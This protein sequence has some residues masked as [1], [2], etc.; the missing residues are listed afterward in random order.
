MNHT[1]LLDYQP[2]PA[3]TGFIARAMLT[4]TGT[5]PQN[6]ARVPLNLSLVLDRSG[7]MS[8]EKL[9]AATQAAAQ[10]VRR[11]AP[12]DRVNVVAFDDEIRTV[13]DATAP[14]PG[15][16]LA[17]RIL[18][19]PA[20][21]S[22]NLSGGW[23]RG[24][25]LAKASL[26]GQSVNRVLLLTDG[27]ANCGIQDH[28]QLAKLCSTAKAAG[29][30]TSTVGFG[31][32]Y[33]EDLLKAMADAGGGNA[34][35]IERADQAADVFGEELSGLLS[36]SAQNVT[37]LVKPAANVN[38]VAVLQSYPSHGG[39][40]GLQI[41]LGDLY[42]REP[43]VLVLEFLVQGTP[44]EEASI[45]TLV[46]SADVLKGDGA[47]EH[48]TATYPLASSLDAAGRTEP[49]IEREVLLARASKARDEAA[50]LKEDGDAKGSSAVVREAALR[51]SKSAFAKDPEFLEQA[52]DLRAMAKRL[53]EE[54]IDPS[55][56]KYMK[57]RAYNGSRG[58]Q[59]YD[60]TLSRGEP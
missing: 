57:Q 6:A 5:A 15:I 7:S 47:V 21:G 59:A 24:R 13:A 58:R 8:G 45:G 9:E 39:P 36:L 25:E 34:W 46:V 51:L 20:G 35:Y 4:L 23:L 52:K 54:A 48:V 31:A 18:A 40:A 27:Q 2:A 60:A 17:D 44:G 12:E 55:D 56:I 29:V 32:D 26:T 28:D 10:L 38:L 1:L 53:K 14:E 22:T 19:I 43:R 42:A 49:V 41:E 37:V 33:D 30:T 11:L 50:R 3:G 16:S